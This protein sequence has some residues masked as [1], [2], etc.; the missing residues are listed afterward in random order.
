MLNAKIQLRN[1]RTL[2]F[3][4]VITGVQYMSWK[5]RA[6]FYKICSFSRS[7]PRYLRWQPTFLEDDLGFM[8]QI[9][10]YTFLT[11]SSNTVLSN[12]PLHS[13]SNKAVSIRTANIS[14]SILNF[15][16]IQESWQTNKQTEK[17]NIGVSE[18][19]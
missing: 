5:W 1:F 7:N 12:P 6:C 13:R 3:V 2:N 4:S 9:K 18:W 11:W 19:R 8:L 15:L 10:G 17:N 14:D 16:L